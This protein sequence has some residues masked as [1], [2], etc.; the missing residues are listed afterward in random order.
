MSATATAPQPAPAQPPRV[1]LT[2]VDREFLPA[3]LEI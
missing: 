3:A 2:P 1:K